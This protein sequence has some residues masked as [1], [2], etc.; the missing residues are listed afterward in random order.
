MSENNLNKPDRSGLNPQGLRLVD[1]AK[2]LSL[3][4]PKPVTVEMLQADIDDGAPTNP[5]G[6]ISLVLYAAWLAK[7]VRETTHGGD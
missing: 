7:N 4:G 3:S 2:I 5:D 1:L 6:S